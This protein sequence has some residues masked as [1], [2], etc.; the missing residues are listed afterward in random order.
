MQLVV[1]FISISHSRHHVIVVTWLRDVYDRGGEGRSPPVMGRD[2]ES[3]FS[4]LK[5]RQRHQNVHLF[6]WK[7]K[8]NSRTLPSVG[9]AHPRTLPSAL[10]R[11]APPRLVRRLRHFSDGRPLDGSKLRSNFSLCGP[12]YRFLSKFLG[13]HCL[14]P[15]AIV[16]LYRKYL[17]T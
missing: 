17:Q 12:T 1:S 6:M 7:I 2:R 10:R 3:I 15:N 16:R 8:K 5:R 14:P 11:S 9:R 13:R 4:L